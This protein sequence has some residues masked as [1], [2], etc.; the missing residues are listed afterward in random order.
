VPLEALTIAAATFGAHGLAFVTASLLNLTLPA[1]ALC[2][3]HAAF[4][5]TA[6]ATTLDALRVNLTAAA[7]ALRLGLTTSTTALGLGFS[8]TAALCLS[9][10]VSAAA[11]VGF[12]GGRRGNR[13]SCDT[14]REDEVPHLESP[15][16]F[17]VTTTLSRHRSTF[18]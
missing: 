15:I 2:L 14:R 18:R 7:A 10:T 5:A 8:A 9:L 3:G 1:T 12:G 13:K 17:L 6:T 4:T 11:F 16:R